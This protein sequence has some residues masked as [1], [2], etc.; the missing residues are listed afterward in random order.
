MAVEVDAEALHLVAL[1]RSLQLGRPC[2]GGPALGH[3]AGAAGV[4]M[5]VDVDGQDRLQGSQF[6][7][8]IAMGTEVDRPALGARQLI[9]AANAL[10][11]I[12]LRLGRAW[13]AGACVLVIGAHTSSHQCPFEAASNLSQD[14]PEWRYSKKPDP[15]RTI[16]HQLILDVSQRMR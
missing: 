12:Y 14:R 8:A 16:D 7:V 3:I 9:V 10:G 15:L 6:G 11:L 2:K 13:A 5:T 4:G 1:G